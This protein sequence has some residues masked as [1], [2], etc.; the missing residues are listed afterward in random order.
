MLNRVKKLIFDATP[1]PASETE[2]A[3]DGARKGDDILIGA[4]ALLVEAAV[5][6]GDFG[7]VE[8]STI[9]DILVQRLK[10]NEDEAKDIL[11]AAEEQQKHA[12]Q[13]LGYTRL[14]KDGFSHEERVEIIEMLW[15]V[16]YAD[17]VLHDYEANL[18]RRV[19][20]LIYV[21]DRERGDARRRVLARMNADGA[22]NEE[23]A[24]C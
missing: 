1:P 9:N 19:G 16:A 17:G 20:G 8:R 11:L 2:E 15:E 6:D 18:L 23:T 22:D 14:I 5:L 21:S 24:A 10:L 13:L 7:P 12:N 4:C 3:S